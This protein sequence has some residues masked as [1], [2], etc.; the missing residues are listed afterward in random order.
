MC[1]MERV[2]VLSKPH[3]GLSYSA[4][5][6]EFNVIVITKIPLSINTHKTRLSIDELT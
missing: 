4:V 6:L 3:S 5:G 1:L 2:H